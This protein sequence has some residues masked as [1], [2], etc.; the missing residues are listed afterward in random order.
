MWK[1][2]LGLMNFSCKSIRKPQI[3]F[4]ARHLGEAVITLHTSTCKD[5]LVTELV[6]LEMYFIFKWL[7]CDL[8]KE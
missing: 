6:R 7:L 1:G 8:L 2:S 4:H 5:H 3:K